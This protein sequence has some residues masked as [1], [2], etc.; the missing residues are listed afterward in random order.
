LLEQAVGAAMDLAGGALGL[1]GG[2]K[3]ETFSVQVRGNAIKHA[4]QIE[5]ELTAGDRS[6]KVM[7]GDVQRVESSFGQ[8][9]IVGAT[10]KLKLAN[11]RLN[12]VYENQTLRQIVVDLTGQA[13]VDTGEIET[14]NSYSYFIV[15]ES[16]S[17]LKQ[18]RELAI[19]DGLDVYFNIDNKLILKKFNKTS[20]DHTFF[21]GIDILDVKLSNHQAVSD[22]ILVY[23]ESPASN[24]GSSTWHW[25][26]KDLSP[27]RSE[28]GQGAKVLAIQDGAI[29]TKDAA[30]SL[31]TS[32]FGAIK[33]HSAHG[34]LKI[35]GNP[36]VKLGDAM[37]IKNAP[38]P[39]LN[40]LFK[41][42]S[43]R[44]VLNKRDGY[45][46]FIGFSG[47]GGAQKAGGL[48]GELAGQLMGALV[49]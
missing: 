41:I 31:A 46:T 11:A 4:D 30:D 35:L 16:K 26:A 40:G 1:G 36:Q 23:G 8:T 29:R 15:H 43:V 10:G 25:L 38:Q 27:F 12:Q 39:E 17:L 48:L 49:L 28:V 18:I 6:A 37:E 32:K 20:A 44:H 9:Q 33:D 14:G 5:V 19:R 21:Y 22:H 3:E 7:T 47:L 24:Q 42:T 2:K 45:L 13:D 34:R